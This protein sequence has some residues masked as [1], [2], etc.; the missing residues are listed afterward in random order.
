MATEEVMIHFED[1]DAM[2][3][4]PRTESRQAT[5]RRRRRPKKRR[6][7]AHRNH[8]LTRQTPKERAASG[9]WPTCPKRPR[10]RTTPTRRDSRAF[11]MPE[12]RTKA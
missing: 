11:R 3:G 7:C 4:L 9:A 6:P 1:L 5:A 10:T 12:E 2:G 8:R